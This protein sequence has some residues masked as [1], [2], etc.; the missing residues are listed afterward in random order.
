MLI[1]SAYIYY[2]DNEHFSHK[3][4]STKMVNQTGVV[5]GIYGD[6]VVVQDFANTIQIYNK[7]IS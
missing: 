7:K 3:F 1:S 6:N 4:Y 2:I 5:G